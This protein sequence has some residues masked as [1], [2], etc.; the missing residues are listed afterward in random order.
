MSF[1]NR[2]LKMINLVL[3][4][5]ALELTEDDGLDLPDFSIELTDWL[6]QGGRGVEMLETMALSLL[7]V[8]MFLS[9]TLSVKESGGEL[10][11]CWCGAQNSVAVRKS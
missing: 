10:S 3:Y 1:E 7:G 8:L 6:S 9:S 4:N 2:N 11:R 5:L